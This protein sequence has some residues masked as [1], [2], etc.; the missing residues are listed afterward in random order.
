MVRFV[1]SLRYLFLKSFHL[2]LH[3]FFS[4]RLVRF[5]RYTNLFRRLRIPDLDPRARSCRLLLSQ[6]LTL[7]YFQS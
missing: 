6:S 7:H 5:Y 3:C 4:D 2:F 1:S